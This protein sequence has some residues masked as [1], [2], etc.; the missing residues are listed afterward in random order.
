[1][2]RV[3]MAVV[4]VVVMVAAPG[5]ALA[6]PPTSP[7]DY[8]V[9][10][11]DN[12]ILRNQA[13]AIDGDVGSNDGTVTVGQ[14]VRVTG[15]VVGRTIRFR[16]NTAANEAYCLL[17]ENGPGGLSCQAVTLPVIATGLLPGVQVVPGSTRINVT[18]GSSTSPL[19]AGAYGNVRVR[20][21]GQL[22]L[23]GGTYAFRSLD[24]A[25]RASLVCLAAFHIG[26]AN[27]VRVRS[28]ASLSGGSGVAVR[29]VRLSIARRGSKPA[30]I[31]DGRS[32]VAA[33]VYAPG[34]P[35]ELRKR[36]NFV[37]SFV[38]SAVRVSRGAIVQFKSR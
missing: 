21:R 1:M 7:F 2:R 11:L 37:G 33:V 29:N 18:S 5:A 15:A 27:R 4:A 10:A 25:S 19:P 30:F 9:F 38:G 3:V 22:R 28:R 32:N 36:G 24:L 12:L 14:D 8:A 20:S 26:V 23:A 17:L 16:K 35:I 13:R 6:D 31:G 34:S